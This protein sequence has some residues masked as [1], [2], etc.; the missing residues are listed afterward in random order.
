MSATTEALTFPDYTVNPNGG[1]VLV[2]NLN[3]H[4]DKGDMAWVLC[5]TL[6]C[7]QITPVRNK[8]TSQVLI[9]LGYW[10]SI[11]WYDETESCWYDVTAVSV[12]CI[13]RGDP[14]LDLWLLNDYV[15]IGFSYYR[16]SRFG[17]PAKHSRL[18]LAI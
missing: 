11:C 5:A 3:L 14:I 9:C 8:L 4:Y 18:W 15:S 10:V 7:W 17:I 1:D 6:F 13:R 16:Q 2:D 12:L